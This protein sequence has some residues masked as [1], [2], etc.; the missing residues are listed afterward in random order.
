MNKILPCPFCGNEEVECTNNYEFY[1]F[2]D[3]FEDYADED[4]PH[5]DIKYAVICDS[6]KGGCG[7]TGGFDDTKEKAI[8]RWNRRSNIDD[9]IHDILLTNSDSATESKPLSEMSLR[10]FFAE[11][12]RRMEALEAKHADGN[13]N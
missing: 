4:S 6:D 12:R 3:D 1:G 10:D 13:D 2:S 11:L 5:D 7:A 8:E 9:K